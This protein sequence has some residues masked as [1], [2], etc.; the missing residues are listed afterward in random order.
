MDQDDED[1]ELFIDEARE[2]IG[3]VE[4][5]VLRIEQKRTEW[6]EPVHIMFGAIHTIKG[7]SLYLGLELLS[8]C[9]QRIE[10][11]L[12]DEDRALELPS[13]EEFEIIYQ[14]IDLVRMYFVELESC[15][16][17]E[18]SDFKLREWLDKQ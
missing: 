18:E 9:C 4:E 11:I 15:G 16:K 6:S 7:N 1:L 14:F 3:E 8:Q 10:T 2:L 13:P 12:A 17:S 5:N